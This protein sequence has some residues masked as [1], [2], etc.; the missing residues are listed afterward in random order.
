MVTAI[1]LM[2]VE[3]KLVNQIAEKLA[4][5]EGISECYSVGGSYDLVAIIRVPRNEDLARLVTEH[6]APLD[7]VLATETLLAFK[8]HSK[9]DLEAMFAVG[10]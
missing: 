5:R 6:I 7:G 2:S 9:H 3:G 4:N 1:V 10:L 8:A